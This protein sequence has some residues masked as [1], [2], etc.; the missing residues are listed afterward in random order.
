MAKALAFKRD[1]SEVVT[2]DTINNAFAVLGAA[3][4]LVDTTS[5]FPGRSQN[6]VAVYQGDPYFLYR[7]GSNEVRLASFTAGAWA[8]VAGFTAVTAAGAGDMIPIGLHVVQDYLVAIMAETDAGGGS[9]RLIARTSQ[10]GIAWNATVDDLMPTTPVTNQ[11]GHSI[12][13]R[14]AVFVAAVDGVNYF[15]PINNVWG[16][17]FDTGDDGLL[18]GS[19]L[20]VGNFTFWN[21]DLY[22]VKPDSVPTIYSLDTAFNTTTPPANPMWTNRLPTG[23]PGLGTVTV[24]PDTGTF[25][26]FVN[27]QDQ[28]TLLYSA[29]LGSKLIVTDAAAFPIFTDVTDTLL[30][31][32]LRTTPDLGFSLYVDDRRRV[33]ELQSILIRFPSSG[34]T[35]LASWDGVS[36]VNVRTTFSGVQFMPPDERFGG[37]LR[38]FTDLQPT[39]HITAASQPFPGRVQLNY[40]VRESSSRP[41]D[42]FGEYSI[43]GDVWN[44]MTQGDGD[45]GNEQLASSPAGTAYTFFWDAFVDLDGDYDHMR[46]RIVARISGV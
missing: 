40:T 26:L 39:A 8:D 7:H 20:P 1:T 18:T 43:D 2:I 13:W 35:Q 32:A 10:D 9:D 36:E 24:G 38:T 29:Q 46:M 27:K 33:N 12:A 34:D 19:T 41:V 3:L 11:G 16:A 15:D 25:L 37:E 44:A 17:A 42:I 31:S 30:P 6:I 23:I 14:N 28:L 45:S 5:V 21:N 22:F 4:P